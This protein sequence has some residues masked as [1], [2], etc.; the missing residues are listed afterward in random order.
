MDKILDRTALK[1][2]LDLLR[3]KGKKI[4]FTNGCFDILHVGHVRY[5]KEEYQS[6]RW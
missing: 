6:S 4:A 2:N 5:L 3:K 1:E